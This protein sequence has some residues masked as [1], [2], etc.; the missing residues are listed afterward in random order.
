[1]PNGC[2]GGSGARDGIADLVDV[3]H[4]RLRLSTQSR[5][6]L[7]SGRADAVEILRTNRDT[8]DEVGEC[9]AILIDS[10]LARKG[11]DPLNANMIQ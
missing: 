3:V 6:V 2:A 1:M 11:L 7:N 5:V 8:G 9:R 4:E 10:A